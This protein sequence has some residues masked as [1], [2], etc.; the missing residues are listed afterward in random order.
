MRLSFEGLKETMGNLVET[1]AA[2]VRGAA[3]WLQ[4]KSPALGQFLERVANKIESASSHFRS[5][6]LTKQPPNAKVAQAAFNAGVAPL[7]KQGP[8][9]RIALMSATMDRVTK[10]GVRSEAYERLQEDKSLKGALR[11]ADLFTAHCIDTGLVD[12]KFF[13]E[14]KDAIFRAKA[15]HLKKE[16][17]DDQDVE[18]LV[19]F[20]ESCAGKAQATS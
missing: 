13:E 2:P 7:F 12:T 20:A 16:K 9:H 19:S 10:S 8:E 6:P 15:N 14:N 18:L 5:R 1:S 11:R 17:L 3:V 4:R